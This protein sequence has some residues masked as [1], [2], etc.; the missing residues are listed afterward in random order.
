MELG[1]CFHTF[2]NPVLTHFSWCCCVCSSLSSFTQSVQGGNVAPLLCL[3]ALCKRFKWRGIVVLL[4]TFGLDLMFLFFHVFC[5]GIGG[6]CSSVTGSLCP[7]P[8]KQAAVIQELSTSLYEQW[9]TPNLNFYVNRVTQWRSFCGVSSLKVCFT[10]SLCFVH[11][12][13][14]YMSQKPL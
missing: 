6:S 2:I 3:T 11:R 1:T 5:N 14:D 7:E 8:H 9:L 10:S 12:W 4:L 13:R